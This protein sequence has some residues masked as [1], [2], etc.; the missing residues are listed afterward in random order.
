MTVRRRSLSPFA[1]WS[2][3]CV[4]IIGPASAQEKVPAATPMPQEAEVLALGVRELGAHAALGRK[5]GYPVR[6]RQVWIELLTEYAPDAEAA[7]KA[8]GFVRHGSVWRRDPAFLW[9]RGHAASM[10]RCTGGGRAAA[11]T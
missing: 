4:A 10:C 6:V 8:L 1:A 5:N 9:R 11:T 2:C 3:A 7:R